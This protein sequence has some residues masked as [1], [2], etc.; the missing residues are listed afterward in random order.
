MMDRQASADRA[1]ASS[2]LLV[3]VCLVVVVGID[4]PSERWQ[5]DPRPNHSDKDKDK[6]SRLCKL[7]CMGTENRQKLWKHSPD[8]DESSSGDG[9]QQ[10]RR[11]MIDKV[12][13]K[14]LKL[15]TRI[16]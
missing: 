9:G 8:G 7:G 2:F 1:S 5:G 16:E 15:S 11:P 10:A 13:F 6:D 3:V 12:H 14:K 4:I